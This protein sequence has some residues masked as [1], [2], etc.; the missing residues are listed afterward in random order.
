MD[1]IFGGLISGGASLLSS[2]FSSSTSAS[3]TQAQIA[4]QQQMQQQSEQFNAA[5]AQKTR[6]FTESMSN[7]A[8]AR[9]SADMKNA[10]LNPAVM[11]GSGSAASTPSGATASVG[12][13]A[14]PTSQKTSMLAG[15]GNAV[16]K[17]VSSAISVKTFEKM[18]DEIAK[19]QSERANIDATTSLRKQETETEKEETLRRSYEGLKSGMGIT[20]ARVASKEAEDKLRIPDWLRS[21]AVQGG[22]LGDKVSDLVGPLGS[23]AKGLI[24]LRP[25]RSTSETTTDDG[26]SSFTERF[27]YN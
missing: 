7:T 20:A 3:N 21:A 26:R 8:Y 5:E 22:Y 9:A 24:G 11:F 16:D 6:D 4:A 1:P 27:H 14:V 12:T 19:L 15:L 18:T 13:P 17:V 25:K 10:G 23:V 2:I